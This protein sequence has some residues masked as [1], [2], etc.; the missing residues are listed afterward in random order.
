MPKSNAKLARKYKEKYEVLWKSHE[1]LKKS[2][3]EIYKKNLKHIETNGLFHLAE[4]KWRKQNS[5][6]LHEN[7]LEV[8]KVM[9]LRKSLE[10]KDK[11][12]IDLKK[13]IEY[14]KEQLRRKEM[15]ETERMKK[16]I[17]SDF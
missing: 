16:E 6:L 14:L 7:S 12:V 2:H 11:E 5:Y 15:G 3:E 17:P 10:D 1:V 8:S 13:E 4:Q 9:K